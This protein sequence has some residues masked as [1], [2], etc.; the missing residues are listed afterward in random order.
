MQNSEVVQQF[1]LLNMFVLI[2]WILFFEPSR[3]GEIREASRPQKRNA[4]GIS[5]GAIASV[6]HVELMKYALFCYYPG[7]KMR[8]MGNFARKRRYWT[9]DRSA[10]GFWEAHLEACDELAERGL[11]DVV[12]KHYKEAFRMTKRDF[13]DFVQQY[14]GLVDPQPSLCG[15]GVERAK[16]VGLILDWL[17]HGDYQRCL[18]M[19]YA[20]RYCLL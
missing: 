1:I 11:H 15:R 2:V 3:S 16:R 10:G 9:Q 7:L 18:A 4:M 5:V 17:A 8:E 14:G 12:D 6:Q 19:K 13:E 20:P